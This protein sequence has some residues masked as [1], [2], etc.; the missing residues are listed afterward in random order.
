MTDHGTHTTGVDYSVHG[1]TEL[2][3]HGV[4]GTPAAAMLQHS[5]VLLKRVSGDRRAGFYRRWYPGGTTPDSD[6]GRTE[7]YSWGGLTSG[8]ASRALWLLFLPFVLVDL[9]HWMLPPMAKDRAPVS[10]RLA[11]TLLRLLALSITFTFLVALAVV[12]LDVGAW[13]CA[14][15]ERCSRR[16]AP[17]GWITGLDAGGRLAVAALVPALVVVILWRLGRQSLRLPTQ[18]QTGPSLPPGPAVSV[19]E[20]PLSAP[21][22]WMGDVSELRLRAV[23]ISAWCSALGALVLAP[24]VQLADESLGRSVLAVFLVLHLT[25]LV[26]CI[27]VTCSERITGRGGDGAD[28]TTRPLM[29]LRWASFLLLL[30]GLVATALVP[31]PWP[32]DATYLVSPTE[33]P[34]LREVVPALFYVQ[35]ALLVALTAAV[36]VQRPGR[37]GASRPGFHVALRGYAAPTTAFAAWLTAVAFGVGLGLAATHY[38]GVAV[39]SIASAEGLLVEEAKIL[40]DPSST[41]AARIGIVQGDAPLILPP[42]YFWTGTAVVIMLAAFV[43]VL[44]GVVVYV[45]RAT[46]ALAPQI[47]R[48]YPGLDQPDRARTVAR[49]RVLAG[50]TDHVD[51]IL[52]PLLVVAV[53]EVV[54]GSV[55]FRTI[56]LDVV[57]KD[58][59]IAPWTAFG[60]WITGLVAAGLVSL[61]FLAFRDARVRRYVGILWDV[62]TFWPRANHPLTPPSY[63]E[64]AVPELER[65]TAE[66]T[67]T[68]GDLVVLTAHSQGSVLA[69]AML[70][71]ERNSPGRVALLTYGSPLRRLYAR[72]FPAYFG[73]LAFAAT[74]RGTHDATSDHWI[75]LWTES[76]PIGAW[77]LKKAG[78][79]DRPVHEP[80][81]LE[82]D[83]KGVRPPTCGHSGYAGFEEYAEAIRILDNP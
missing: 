53:L 21:T 7:A 24:A 81:S 18:G 71:R 37:I 5:E 77:V 72:F 30:A 49:G 74:A 14:P 13:Q 9:A 52:G 16:F 66:L 27:A 83:D 55:L 50:L 45:L 1:R 12:T 43:L 31:V 65:R 60:V 35:V 22:F 64:R 40:A 78:F 70:M 20:L 67:S 42:G 57:E 47:E 54:V 39:S 28:R 59:W 25:V 11:S 58:P 26:A 76:D 3:V 4:S 41:L 51:A 19:A 2:R 79:V 23:H 33:L 63:G 6:A 62:A 17:L 15:V 69:A 29:R 8:P 73:P 36:A 48:Q 44:L 34:Y 82:L 32:V 56:R 46:A 68:E 75:N 80:T 10:A 61:G 38:L